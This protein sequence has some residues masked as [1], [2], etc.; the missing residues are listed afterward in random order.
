M[1][2]FYNQINQKVIILTDHT[3]FLV[4]K[5]SESILDDYFCF[6]YIWNMCTFDINKKPHSLTLC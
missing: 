6:G 4:T 1:N 2:E 3:N 5:L